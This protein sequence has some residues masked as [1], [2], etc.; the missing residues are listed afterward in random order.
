MPPSIPP[1]TD[2]ELLEAV[3]ALTRFRVIEHSGTS[4]PS[5]IALHFVVIVSASSNWIVMACM[6]ASF[7]GSMAQHDASKSSVIDFAS[8]AFSASAGWFP[9]TQ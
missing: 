3:S 1:I 6:C 4:L 7:A 5:I 8:A 9:I 2:P